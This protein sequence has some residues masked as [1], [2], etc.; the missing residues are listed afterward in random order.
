M[1]KQTHVEVPSDFTKPISRVE[2]NGDGIGYVEH[3]D[4]SRANLS[5]ESRIAAISTVASICYQSPKAAGSISLYNRLANESMGLPSSSFEF[6]P[7][8]LTMDLFHYCMQLQENVMFTSVSK[9]GEVVEDGEYLLTNLRALMA[10]IGDR[11]DGFFNTETECAI[12]AKHHKVFQAKMPIWLSKQFNR[13]RVS[14]QE[15]SRR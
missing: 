11:A 9:F 5:N 1:G 4:F 8:L 2:L 13:H 6:V 12:I 10:D 14:L 7:V 3:Y 15:L